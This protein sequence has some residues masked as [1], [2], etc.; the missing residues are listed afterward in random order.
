MGLCAVT[1]KSLPHAKLTP[2]SALRPRVT[3]IILE[4]HPNLESDALVSE[5]VINA[6]RVKY[7]H[8][9]L[10]SQ[11]GELTHLDEE[12]VTSLHRHE[13]L[14]ERPASE[15]EQRQQLTLG[16]RLSDRIASFGGSWRFIL[17][18]GGFLVIWIL[19]NVLALTGK[20][21]DP[22]PFILLNL[23]LSCIAAMQAP[24]IMMSQNRVEIR[25]RQRAESDYKI[26][27]KA[28]LEIRHLHEKMD[29]LL[30]R[31]ATQLMEIQNIQLE[32]LRELASNRQG[33]H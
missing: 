10:E 2:L 11:L 3:E 16:E 21:F 6:A 7:V 29:Y 30:H 4:E 14:S 27:L 20:S 18:F 15:H 32:L 22:Y 25:D 26:N 33:E 24:V 9:L 12:V 1:G 31:H 13:L 28:E 8:N 17:S 5:E 23:I 19:I